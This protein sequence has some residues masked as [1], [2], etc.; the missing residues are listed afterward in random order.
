[1]ANIF[2]IL[3]NLFVK[4]MKR[5]NMLECY[6]ILVKAFFIHNCWGNIF[7]VPGS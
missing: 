4:S 2:F 7:Y 5:T 1:M 3:Q 6:Q